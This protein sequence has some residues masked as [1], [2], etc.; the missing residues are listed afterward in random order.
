MPKGAPSEGYRTRLKEWKDD[1]EGELK[2]K[3]T[4]DEIVRGTGVKYSTLQKHVGHVF[5]SPDY[6]IAAKI[7]AFFNQMSKAKR[8]WTPLDYFVEVPESTEDDGE[9]QRD[10]GGAAREH[11]RA[12][13]S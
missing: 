11:L 1:L 3:V 9:K 2:R 10:P 6:A 12:G 8:K 5:T 7:S 4:W 13:A